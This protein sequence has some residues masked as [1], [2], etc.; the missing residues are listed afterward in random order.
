MVGSRKVVVFM[1]PSNFVTLHEYKPTQID[2]VWYDSDFEEITTIPPVTLT[3][4]K[5]GTW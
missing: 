1:G 5:P 2:G 3:L 4:S